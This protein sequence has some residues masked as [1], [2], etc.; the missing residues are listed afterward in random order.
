[1]L[2][3]IKLTV[4]ALCL[5]SAAGLSGCANAVYPRL[6]ILSGSD[7]SLLSPS[8]QKQAIQDLSADQK[9]HGSKAAEEIERG[10]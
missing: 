1:M 8:E 7:G 9:Q 3:G 4:L 5:T 6:P 2:R 10:Q